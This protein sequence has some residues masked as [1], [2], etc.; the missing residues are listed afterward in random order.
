MC[1][2]RE[3]ITHLIDWNFVNIQVEQYKQD[4][5]LLYILG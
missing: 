2:G 3:I 4:I 5:N 1:F